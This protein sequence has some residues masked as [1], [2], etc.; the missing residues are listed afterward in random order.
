MNN[1]CSICSSD[2][3]CAESTCQDYEYDYPGNFKFYKCSKCGLFE[4]Q[5]QLSTEQLLKAYPDEYHGYNYEGVESKIFNFLQNLRL[6]KRIKFYKTLIG[7]EAKILDIGCGDGHYMDHLKQKTGWQ[8]TGIE[9][10]KEIAAIGQEKGREILTGTFENLDFPDTHFDLIIMNH[11]IEHVPDPVALLA[12]ARR[13]LK[14]GGYIIGE[15]PNVDSWDYYC[16]GKHWGGLHVPRHLFN[17]TPIAL[18]KTTIKAGFDNCKVS[19]DLNTSHWALSLQNLLQSTKT[20]KTKL[21]FGRTKYYNLLLIAFIPIN[22][23]AKVFKKS[24]IINFII[25]K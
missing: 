12:K 4:L 6:K 23:L 18:R 5:P 14:P 22:I 13:K 20:F 21:R 8:I 19:H 9:F 3:I 17:F 11:L 1:Q 16:F 10:K 24:G 25:K 15:L 7:K 2:Q